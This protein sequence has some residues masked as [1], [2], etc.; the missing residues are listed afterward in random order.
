MNL[1]LTNIN[2]NLQ[3]LHNLA[4]LGDMAL[5]GK[6]NGIKRDNVQT[7]SAIALIVLG[8]NEVGK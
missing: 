4:E 7:G 3:S 2:G 8:L 1:F 5:G 6:M